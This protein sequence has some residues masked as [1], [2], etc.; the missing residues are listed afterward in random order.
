MRSAASSPLRLKPLGYKNFHETLGDYDA[1]DVGGDRM[2]LRTLLDPP[3]PPFR[4]RASSADESTMTSLKPLA[5]ATAATT[6]RPSRSRTTSSRATQRTSP[7]TSLR[8]IEEYK[9]HV[10]D[11]S[12]NQLSI[13]RFSAPWCRVCRSTNVSWERLASRI[14]K[15]AATP[16]PNYDGTVEGEQIKFFSVHIDQNE[17]TIALKD[18]LQIT[19]VPQGIVHQPKHGAFEEHIPLKREHVGLLKKRLEKYVEGGGRMEGSVG[20]LLEGLVIE[21]GEDES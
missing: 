3:A 14:N 20:L 19:Q 16:T 12:S 2:S 8:T 10:L 9:Q 17:E 11:A 18:S 4:P 13:V 15:M 21:D 1:V 5:E 6:V 7:I